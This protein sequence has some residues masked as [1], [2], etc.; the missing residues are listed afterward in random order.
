MSKWQISDAAM[1]RVQ[2]RV[3]Q[4]IVADKDSSMRSTYRPWETLL[5]AME[6]ENFARPERASEGIVK[7]WM[8]DGE[9]LGFCASCFEARCNERDELREA[10]RNLM[11]GIRAMGRLK[12]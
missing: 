12:L 9:L 7:R 11:N 10:G 3:V 2:K 4:A 5:E 8:R 1:Q 6:P